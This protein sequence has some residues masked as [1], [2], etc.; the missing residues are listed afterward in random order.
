MPDGS[1]LLVRLASS[2]GTAMGIGSPACLAS[3]ANT[4]RASKADIESL[5]G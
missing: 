1:G 4:T 2:G 3:I 5:T